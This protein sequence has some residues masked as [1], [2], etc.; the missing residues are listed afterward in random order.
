MELL[1]RGALAESLRRA[2]SLAAEYGI[3]I[4]ELPS[5]A[6]AEAELLHRTQQAVDERY[7]A[8]DA[9]NVQ[10]LIAQLADTRESREITCAGFLK[11][12]PRLSA[13]G[14]SQRSADVRLTRPSVVI[15]TDETDEAERIAG[16]CKRQIAIKTDT[17]LL[18]ILPGSPGARE[19]LATLIQQAIDP[20]AV[21]FAWSR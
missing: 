13:I 20:L 12:P 11:L 10:S 15:A 16:W 21:A 5:F 6:G 17:R 8:L 14:G 3:N 7:E 1:N 2:S 19:R 4:S 18:V 9:A